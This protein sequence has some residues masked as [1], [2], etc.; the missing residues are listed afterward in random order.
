MDLR[1][2][3]EVTPTGLTD[4]RVEG[5]KEGRSVQSVSRSLAR[6]TKQ[7]ASPLLAA[8]PEEQ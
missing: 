1:Q 2:A 7:A 8:D 4:V 6:R 3:K 5:R